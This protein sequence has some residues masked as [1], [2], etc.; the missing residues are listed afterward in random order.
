M[1]S[2]L[3]QHDMAFVDLYWLPLGAGEANRCV[4]LSGRIFEAVAA[5][6]EHRTWCDLYHTALQVRHGPNRFMI[7]MAPVWLTKQADRGVVSEG[8][9]GLPWLGRSRWFRYEVRRWC[10]GIIPDISEAVASPQRLSTDADQARRVLDLVPAFPTATW[11][12]DELHNRRHVELQQP[13]RLAAGPQ[14]PPCRRHHAAPTWTRTRMDRRPHRR[15]TA[16]HPGAGAGPR[17]TTG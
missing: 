8:P 13:H 1:D 17:I 15:R 16:G 10:N 11:G 2:T 6:H 3:D 12:L 14:R 7:E 4:R 5:R 9:V